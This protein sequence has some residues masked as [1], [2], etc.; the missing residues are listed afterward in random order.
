MEKDRARLL[1][2]GDPLKSKRA[3]TLVEILVVVA[4]IV[5]MMAILLPVLFSAKNKARQMACSSQLRQI[6]LAVSMYSNDHD[7]LGPLGGYNAPSIPPTP[8]AIPPATISGGDTPL[9]RI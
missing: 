3:F 6:G 5:L 2:K 8:V 7:G 1:P 4:I 9:Y